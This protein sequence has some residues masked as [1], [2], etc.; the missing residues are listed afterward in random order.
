MF[1]YNKQ[2]IGTRIRKIRKEKEEMTLKEF[3]ELLDVPI[4]S[5]ISSWERGVNVPSSMNLDLI[6]EKTGVK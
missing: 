2:S 5:I 4:S 1:Q 3:S 6:S